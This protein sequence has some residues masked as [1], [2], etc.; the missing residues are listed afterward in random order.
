MCMEYNEEM[1]YMRDIEDD[2]DD[3][4]SKLENAYKV[5]KL[6]EMF[7]NDVSDDYGKQKIARLRF[8]FAR[9]QLLTLMQEAREKGVKWE[10]SD[11]IR[12]YFYPDS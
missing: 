9:H 8:E 1:N 7:L 6:S 11:M 4:L 2:N 10:N 12:K 5:Y 3:I